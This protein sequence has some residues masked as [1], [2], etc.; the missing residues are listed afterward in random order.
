MALG[1]APSH[2]RALRRFRACCG[3]WA[4]ER[5]LSLHLRATA[6]TARTDYRLGGRIRPIVCKSVLKVT[7]PHQQANQMQS[8]PQVV[9]SHEMIPLEEK[10]FQA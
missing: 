7:L 5:C 8:H 2:F 9:S 1:M 10:P 3:P 4:L 6:L